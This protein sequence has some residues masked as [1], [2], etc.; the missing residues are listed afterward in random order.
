MK[1]VGFQRVPEG[2]R[3]VQES[4]HHFGG[5]HLRRPIHK[6]G[7]F[8]EHACAFGHTLK[9]NH[10]AGVDFG[11]TIKTYHLSEGE[12]PPLAYRAYPA[13][14]TPFISHLCALLT[15]QGHLLVG[16]LRQ[17]SAIAQTSRGW[18]VCALRHIPAFM[19][20]EVS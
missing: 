18:G 15:A 5:G 8:L 19:L 17:G 12:L 4:I 6:R 14:H 20:V 2:R 9:A 1:G 3:V 10:L 7:Q 13:A 16:G 11:Y